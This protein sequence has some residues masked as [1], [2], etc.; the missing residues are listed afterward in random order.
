MCPP[1]GMFNL[2]RDV[3]KELLLTRRDLDTDLSGELRDFEKHHKNMY[4]EL[5]PLCNGTMRAAVLAAG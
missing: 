4:H 3:A 1:G 5:A 2:V